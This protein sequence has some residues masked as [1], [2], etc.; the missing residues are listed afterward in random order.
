VTCS[1]IS[2]E[3]NAEWNE[4]I[5]NEQVIN[6]ICLTGYHGVVTRSCIQS[7]SIGNWSV[8]TGSCNGSFF[9]LSSSLSYFFKINAMWVNRYK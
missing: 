2:N 8:I 5:S 6:G 3:G 9:F 7:G 1:S 4:T